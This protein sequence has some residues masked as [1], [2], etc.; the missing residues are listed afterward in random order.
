MKKTLL[1][2]FSFVLLSS[3]AFGQSFADNFESYGVG[4]YLGASAP[5]WTT[6]SGV[7]G[8]AEDVRITDAEAASGS[9]SIYF[10]GAAGGGPQDVV[11]FY[12]GDKLTTGFLNTKMNLL[13][14]TGAYF[15]YQAEETIGTTWAMNAFFEAGGNGR[16]TGSGNATI[17]T[18]QYPQ[19]EWFDF[20]MDINFDANK[21]QLSVNGVCVGSFANPD[22]SI[23]SIDLFPLA[24]NSFYVDDFEYEYSAVSP[25]IVEDIS[26][27]LNV[28][29][30][31]GIAGAEIEI[32]GSVTNEGSSDVTAIEIEVVVGSDVLP[33][34][35]DG[36]TLAQG[37]TLEF[38][39][40]DAFMLPEGFTNLDMNI[41]S[42]NGGD[43]ADEDLC[44]NS[45][46]LLLFGTVPAD[47]KKVIVEEA[48]GTWCGWCPR[49]TVWMDRMTNRY[50]DHF[51]GIAVHNGDPMQDAD[52]NSGLGASAFP[53]AV[54]NRNG[55]VD[56][57]S[58]E[59]PFLTDV[60]EPSLAIMENGALW[61]ETTR[62]LTISLVV[63]SLD[64]ISTNH[65]INIALTEDN[66][67]GT[68]NGWGQ[69]NYYSNSQDLIDDNGVNWRDLPATV[70]GS[71]IEYDHVARAIL[72]PFDGLSK[73]FKDVLAADD[74]E[75]FNF[76]YTVPAG[77]D[78]ENMHIVTMLINPNGTINTG[79]GTTIMEAVENGFSLVS[80]THSIELGNATSVYPN[81]MSQYTTV[82]I[83]LVERSDVN[84]NIVDMSGKLL[85]QKTYEGRNGFFRTNVNISD[86]PTGN[87]IMKINTKDFYTTKK[88]SVIR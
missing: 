70:P 1:S 52:Y 38:V 10:A 45:A 36:F 51:I 57:A 72:A 85:M 12:G 44:N 58:I 64:E 19:G 34:S 87:Y 49:G 8:T 18:F 55:F 50:P 88:I 17:L 7:T 74:Q 78:E 43:F 65:K 40:D 39:I 47:H 62:E 42:V 21:W 28:S 9:K 59:A 13:V 15:N 73:S 86:L 76:T 82:D 54:V 32:T 26:T 68:G 14:E 16:I 75:V 23:A 46:S 4:D 29:R 5:E 61:D 80:S 56:P 79:E 69:V 66:V 11:L 33:Y 53:G 84:I 35:Q 25:P 22:N 24:G 81:P 6:W 77:F 41:V 60:K 2:I 3:L 30:E 31:N 63:T 20:E 48:T 37:E 71:D 67:S 27:K 83:N